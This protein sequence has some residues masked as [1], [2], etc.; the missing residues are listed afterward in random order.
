MQSAE[1]PVRNH[2][3]AQNGVSSTKKLQSESSSSFSNNDSSQWMV[4]AAYPGSVSPSC[5]DEPVGS[6]LLAG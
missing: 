2:H 1:A 6:S 5:D 3:F 4:M